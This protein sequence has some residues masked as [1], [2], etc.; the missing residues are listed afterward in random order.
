AFARVNPRQAREF[1]RAIVERAGVDAEVDAIP[2]SEYPTPAR[3]PR[4]SVLDTGKAA[5]V[6]GPPPHWR[7]ALDRYLAG[8]AR[9]R[10]T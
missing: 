9:I 10:S 5:A 6:V 2:G 7:D 3:R 1:A 8:R 4:H